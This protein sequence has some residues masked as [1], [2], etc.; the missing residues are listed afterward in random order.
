MELRL[1][2]DRTTE[3]WQLFLQSKRVVESVSPAPNT[4][5]VVGF[6]LVGRL[7]QQDW[8]AR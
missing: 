2:M 3:I 8:C 4:G 5:S 1:W 6:W 7:I